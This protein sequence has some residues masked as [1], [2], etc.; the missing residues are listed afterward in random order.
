VFCPLSACR[1]QKFQIDFAGKHINTSVWHNHTLTVFGIGDPWLCYLV[2]KLKWIMITDVC[3][4]IILRSLHSKYDL[5]SRAKDYRKCVYC[6]TLSQI[7]HIV[8]IEL[9]LCT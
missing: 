1:V 7:G 2:V 9:L 4:C 6:S 5:I 3:Y 8:G